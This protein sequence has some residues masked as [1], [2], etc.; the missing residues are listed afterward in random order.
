MLGNLSL[1]HLARLQQPHSLGSPFSH[2]FSG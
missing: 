2:L 1:V